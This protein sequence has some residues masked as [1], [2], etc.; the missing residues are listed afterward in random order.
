MSGGVDSSVAAALLKAAAYDVVGIT[1]RLY[2]HGA[3][4]R[5]AGACC[6]GQD[7]H[8][9]RRVAGH[10]GI[11]HYVL[12]YES[13]FKEAV[14]ADFVDSYRRGETPVPCVQCNR[15]VKFCDLLGTARDLGAAALVTGHYA[16]RLLGP[17]GPELHRA[18]DAKRDQSYFLFATATEQLAFLRF[19]LGDLPKDET[20]RLAATFGLSVAEKP[21]SQDICFVPGGRYAEV[22]ERLRP[23]AAEPGEIVDLQGKVLGR[24]QG[25]IHYT[26]G[27]RRGLGGGGSEPQY[28]VRLDAATRRVVVG[29]RSALAVSG[30]R[31]R[32][33]NWLTDPTT[34]DPA[35]V[36]VQV[37]STQRPAPARIVAGAGGTATVLLE[38]PE[39]GVSPGQACVAY[40]HERVLGGGWIASTETADVGRSEAM[41]AA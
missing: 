26:V 35:A 32:Q 7:I 8:D 12:D 27:Q 15:T 16:R 33:M 25:I 38:Q 28:V 22:I 36:Q 10:L 29:P 31:L 37:R 1:L 24:H 30:I 20:R 14:I 19:P 4:V 39:Q 18:L 6:A 41:V 40:A 9:A 3:A 13:R 21:D 34:I 2:E 17:D 23:G 11:P 5:R